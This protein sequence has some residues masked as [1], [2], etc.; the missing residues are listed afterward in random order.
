[1]Y[2]HLFCSMLDYMGVDYICSLIYEFHFGIIFKM[3]FL[4]DLGALWCKN[5]C[6]KDCH[7]CNMYLSLLN[8][9]YID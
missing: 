7:Q 3:F 1:M 4:Q 8:M 5:V 9:I 2:E 6:Y